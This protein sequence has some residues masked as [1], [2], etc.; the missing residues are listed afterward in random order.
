M[1]GQQNHAPDGANGSIMVGMF[2]CLCFASQKNP[3]YR[4]FFVSAGTDLAVKMLKSGGI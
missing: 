2:V 1:L 4:E 3:S